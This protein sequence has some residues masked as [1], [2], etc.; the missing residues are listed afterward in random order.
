MRDR[1]HESEITVGDGL[2]EAVRGTRAL[3]GH[4]DAV[5]HG[6]GNSSWKDVT[7]D[8]TG[9][10]HD[11]IYVKGSGWNMGTIERAG[12]APLRLQRVRELLEVDAISDTELVNALRL[13]SFDSQAPDASIEAPLHAL[14]P[15]RAVLHSHA[16]AIVALT[17][18]PGGE[19]LTRRVFG[20]DVVVVPYVMPGF[21]LAKIV[22]EIWMREATERTVGLLLLRHGL[23]TF[24]DSMELAYRRHVEL[25]T[26][27]EEAL[28]WAELV[29]PEP[30][31]GPEQAPEEPS[32][33]RPLARLR[34]DISRA[35]GRAM[36]ASRYTDAAVARFLARDDLASIATRGPATPDHVIRTKPVPLIGRDVAAFARAYAEYFA[37]NSGR[38]P[39][40]RML[41]PAP[42]FV[43]DPELGLVTVGATSAEA[44]AV[45]DIALH[46]MNVITAAERSESY[47]PLDESDIFDIEYWELEQ[48]KLRRGGTRPPLTGQVAVVTGAASGIGRACA[49][50]LLSLGAA[51]VGLDISDT[52]TETFDSDSWLGIVTDV[53]S[54]DATAAALRTAVERFG[55]VDLL[56]VAAGVFAQSAPI[57]AVDPSTWDRTF[58]INVDCV[59]TL[60]GQVHPLL[61]ESPVQPRVVVVGSKNV[62]APGPGAAA[63]SASKAALTQL[64]RIAALEWAPDGIRVNVVHPD[65]VFDTALWNDELLEERARKYGV[66]VDEYKRRNLLSTT[67]TSANVAKMV[68]AMCTDAFAATT[69]AQVPV[70]GGNER[71]V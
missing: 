40:L 19:A 33:P 22:R 45:R 57:T 8:V 31:Q 41:D 36:L 48:A 37:R 51:V 13:A 58:A 15:H 55:G 59:R 61:V 20:A 56:V 43:L 68:G 71:V 11:V 66:T 63:Y 42:R 21:N 49:E 6:G 5:L 60:L 23:F 54:T 62:A 46:T 4:A 65:A 50:E 18:Q 24:G 30:A 67:V 2:D 39:E 1:W 47:R 7:H 38:H 64:A 27:A 26:A 53:T 34:A 35:A 17:D 25:I 12:F 69:G 14:L 9:E 70:D 29:A 28:D 32:D 52:I 10:Q 44:A 16:D 3:G